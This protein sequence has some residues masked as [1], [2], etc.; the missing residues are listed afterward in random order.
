LAREANAFIYCSAT[1]RFTHTEREREWVNIKCD[2]EQQN[3]KQV[4]LWYTAS[5][6]NIK[7][8]LKLK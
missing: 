7:S 6:P 2:T 1:L 5:P 3:F 8:E 4:R